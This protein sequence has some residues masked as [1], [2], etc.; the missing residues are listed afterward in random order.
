MV[1]QNSL[2]LQMIN[3]PYGLE[4]FL[5]KFKLGVIYRYDD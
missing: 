5:K 2:K 3:V 4:A 1:N